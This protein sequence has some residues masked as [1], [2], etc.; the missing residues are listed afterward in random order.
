[1]QLQQ[2]IKLIWNRQQ[3]SSIPIPPSALKWI[4]VVVC[5]NSIQCSKTLLN[6]KQTNNSF[7]AGG[8]ELANL[9]ANKTIILNFGIHFGKLIQSLNQMKLKTFNLF[10]QLIDLP[11]ELCRNNYYNSNIVHGMRTRYIYVR[12][13]FHT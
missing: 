10:V 7:N 3:T 12:L 5:L 2:Q 4:V 11:N 9:T 8:M 1:M 13:V 6:S